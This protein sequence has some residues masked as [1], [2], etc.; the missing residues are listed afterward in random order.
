MMM[1]GVQGSLMGMFNDANAKFPGSRS[2]LPYAFTISSQR[3]FLQVASIQRTVAR[4]VL[5]TLVSLN[6]SPIASA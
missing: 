5:I 4:A 6:W 1:H 2:Q 3:P